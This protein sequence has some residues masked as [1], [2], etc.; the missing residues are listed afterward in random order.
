VIVERKNV[1]C[2]K[3]ATVEQR[4]GGADCA[5]S[6]GMEVFFS[7]TSLGNG[8]CQ[9]II[10]GRIVNDLRVSFPVD[11][12]DFGGLELKQILAR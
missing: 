4:G 6:A 10:H 7:Q 11:G 1:G 12:H 2:Q 5:R 3:H 9:I 8:H